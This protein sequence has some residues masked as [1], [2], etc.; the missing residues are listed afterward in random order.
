MILQQCVLSH[1]Q[2]LRWSDRNRKSLITRQWTN[3]EPYFGS[4]TVTVTNDGGGAQATEVPE[5]F[6]VILNAEGLL[7]ITFSKGFKD[8][9]AGIAAEIPSCAIGKMKRR[10]NPRRR[11]VTV[12]RQ[13]DMDCLRLRT[14]AYMKALSKDPKIKQALAH[15]KEAVARATGQDAVQIGEQGKM[16]SFIPEEAVANAVQAS[17]ISAGG[18]AVTAAV[19]GASVLG[20]L[21]SVAWYLGAKEDSDDAW[22]I[23]GTPMT[24]PV[25]TGDAT[26]TEGQEECPDDLVC[27][28]SRCK[29]SAGKCTGEWKD[30]PCSPSGQVINGESLWGK[31][32]S[33]VYDTIVQSVPEPL[34]EPS[35]KIPD[36]ECAPSANGETN[37]VNLESSAFEE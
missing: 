18:D 5:A 22:K 1:G 32:W 15:L 11:A 19:G 23:K 31:D 37:L 27:P 21:A 16:L 20:L 36:P 3:S 28:G 33:S 30:C 9:L 25:T 34:P 8:E 7:E 24:V 29:G 35:T 26:E 4:T 12:K 13:P 6:S 2:T 14:N 17:G 10:R